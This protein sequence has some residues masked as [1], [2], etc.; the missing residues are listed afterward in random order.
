MISSSNSFLPIL[1]I[2]LKYGTWFWR[3]VTK[4]DLSNLHS[5]QFWHTYISLQI[6]IL[7]MDRWL[8]SVVSKLPDKRYR[9]V[10]ICRSSLIT[11][12]CTGTMEYTVLSYYT[13]NCDRHWP[14]SDVCLIYKTLQQLVVLSCSSDCSSLHWKISIYYI[15]SFFLI[16]ETRIDTTS[17]ILNTWLA[18]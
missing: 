10:N 4:Q 14:L 8:V 5:P 6:V 13:S 3:D 2:S 9:I 15:L 1:A 18:C 17:N 11:V 12:Y 7:P 16:L